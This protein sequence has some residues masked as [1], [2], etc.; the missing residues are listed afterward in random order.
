MGSDLAYS[1]IL[2]RCWSGVEGVYAGLNDVCRI[3][4]AFWFLCLGFRVQ[5]SGVLDHGCFLFGS[6]KPLN[7]DSCRSLIEGFFVVK[8][9][10]H[11]FGSVVRGY[12]YCY[13]YYYCTNYYSCY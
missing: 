8:L 9:G 10:I 6:G 13:Y 2:A 1:G 3:L 7:R 11:N 4:Q 12:C 5:G